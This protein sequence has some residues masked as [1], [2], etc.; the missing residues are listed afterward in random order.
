[1][2]GDQAWMVSKDAG[3]EA[4]SFPARLPLLHLYC[5]HHFPLP[6]MV[7]AAWS[8]GRDEVGN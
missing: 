2:G 8:G 3:E 1:M 6:V 4:S 7:K 5:A